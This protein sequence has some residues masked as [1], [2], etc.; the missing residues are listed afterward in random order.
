M[1]RSHKFSTRTLQHL[2]RR[3]GEK[4]TERSAFGL[5]ADDSIEIAETFEMWLLGRT[6]ILRPN[7]PMSALARRTGYW[8]HQLKHGGQAR[9]YAISQVHGPGARDWEVHAIVSSPLSEGIEQTIHWLDAQRIG[10]DPLV[11]LLILPAFHVTAFWIESE[12]NQIVVIDRPDWL[13]QLDKEKL[14]HQREF[15]KL[16]APELPAQATPRRPIYPAVPPV[17]PADWRAQKKD[18]VAS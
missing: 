1:S 2:A 4:L 10:G 15:L 6:A 18:I 16:L 14:Y 9:A 12:D 3:L 8:H 13:S 5:V 17:I 11:R 7:A